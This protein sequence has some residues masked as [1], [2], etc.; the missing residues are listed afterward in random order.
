MAIGVCPTFY[1]EG[2]FN[3]FHV[4]QRRLIKNK[5]IYSIDRFHMG[6]QRYTEAYFADD[7]GKLTK[8]TH[9][10]IIAPIMPGTYYFF[11]S[12]YAISNHDSVL[13]RSNSE[14]KNITNQMG[15]EIILSWPMCYHS[16]DGIEE[17][18]KYILGEIQRNSNSEII[19]SIYYFNDFEGR[20]KEYNKLLPM[21]QMLI[22]PPKPMKTESLASWA[23]QVGPGRV[24]DHKPDICGERGDCHLEDFAVL[25]PLRK[26]DT[27]HQRFHHK[28]KDYDY[29][30]DIWSNIHYGYV[31]KVGGF[32]DAELFNGAG[33]AQLAS[34]FPGHKVHDETVTGP[35][36]YDS[37]P[38]QKTI[39]FGIKLFERTAGNAEKLTVQMILDGLEELGDTGLLRDCRVKHICFDDEEFTPA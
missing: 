37:I 22:G 32:A 11:V 10:Q 33:L 8:S 34:D 17:V 7:N 14:E 23:L 38:D 31:G 3:S 29:Y 25:R 30:F 26:G 6:G 20:L 13:N 5:Y 36:K 9:R 27:P 18:A 2:F 4:K 16:P 39:E 24:W 35:R 19:K 15:Q 28:Y 21:R 1:E 12:K